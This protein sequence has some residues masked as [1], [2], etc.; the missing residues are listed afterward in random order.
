MSSAS[1]AE[2][3]R[4]VDVSPLGQKSQN[5]GLAP[6]ADVTPRTSDPDLLLTARRPRFP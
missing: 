3:S 4:V 1:Q 6:A 2:L 5:V